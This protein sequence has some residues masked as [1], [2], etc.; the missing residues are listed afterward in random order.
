MKKIYSAI[1][2]L[3]ATFALSSCGGLGTMG[4]ATGG[5]TTAAE[6]VT[7]SGA[8]YGNILGN[9]ISTFA[10]GIMTNQQS[11]QGTWTY[12]KP[13]VQ[14]ESE[15]LLAKAGGSVAASRTEEKLATYY[16]LVGIKPGA[17]TFTFASDGTCHYA[18]GQRTM[19]GRYTFNAEKKQVTITTQTGINVTAYVSVSLN[20]LGLTFDASKLLQLASGFGA[21]SSQLGI[22]SSLAGSFTGMKIGFAFNK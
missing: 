15:N 20:Q 8:G 1:V 11:I 19:T 4:Q 9:L 2:A 3:V 7:T 13:C 16:Q 22:I 12:A 10:G 18:I 6:A 5:S 14:F 21:Q 17:F